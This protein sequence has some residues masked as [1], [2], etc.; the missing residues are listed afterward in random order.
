MPGRP[1]PEQ[2]SDGASP[3]GQ[4]HTEF[5]P[6]SEAVAS[7][8]LIRVPR[9]PS[10]DKRATAQGQTASMEGGW[11]SVPAKGRDASPPALVL[12]SHPPCLG[13]LHL[14]A[15]VP[16]LHLFSSFCVHSSPFLWLSLFSHILFIAGVTPQSPPTPSP[17][18]G[19]PFWGPAPQFQV[20]GL[21]VPLLART[22]ALYHHTTTVCHCSMSTTNGKPLFLVQNG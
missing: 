22:P 16:S 19:F 4:G 6:I 14:S 8:R 2:V 18:L 3:Q 5:Y 1:P 13:C 21:F 17:V 9:K 7:S 11:S 15:S 20:S 10:S 12:S